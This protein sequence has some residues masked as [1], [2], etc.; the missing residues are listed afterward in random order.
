MDPSFNKLVTI[1]R[2]ATTLPNNLEYN[3]GLVAWLAVA[4]TSYLN[5]SAGLLSQFVI[6]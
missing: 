1:L 4:I 2:T 5:P 3:K 6:S